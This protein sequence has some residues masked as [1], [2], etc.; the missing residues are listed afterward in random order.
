MDKGSLSSQLERAEADRKN[1]GWPPKDPNEYGRI[2]A[3]CVAL[4]AQIDITYHAKRDENETKRFYS[5][6]RAYARLNKGVRN[7][8]QNGIGDRQLSGEGGESEAT[9]SASSDS[10]YDQDG[11]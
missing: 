8:I 3:L 9:E 10:D 4:R 5:A 2:D 11:H 6:A 1:L 7:G